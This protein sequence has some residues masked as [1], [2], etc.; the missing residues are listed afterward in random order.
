MHT[1]DEIDKQWL[2]QLMEKHKLGDH[3]IL[4]EEETSQPGWSQWGTYANLYKLFMTDPDTIYI[5]MDDDVVSEGPMSH[6]IRQL[7]LELDVR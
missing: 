7:I 5:K 6:Q 2:R 1:N 4:R 3:Y